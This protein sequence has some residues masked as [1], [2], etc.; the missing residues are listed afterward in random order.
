MRDRDTHTPMPL[1]PRWRGGEELVAGLD[2]APGEGT[3]ELS[4]VDEPPQA[5][6]LSE[7][8]RQMERNYPPLL[9]DAGVGGTVQVRFRVLEDGAVDATSITVVSSSHEQ[10]NEATDRSVRRLRFRPATVAAKPVRV[11]V[12]FPV[13]WTVAR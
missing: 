2:G 1:R 11:W 4:G 10:F 9:R 7:F 6:N 8:Q 5:L 12:D 13:Q 3:Y